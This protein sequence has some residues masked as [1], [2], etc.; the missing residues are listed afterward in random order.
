MFFEPPYQCLMQGLIIAQV[1][2]FLFCW[3]PLVFFMVHV[4]VWF[5]LDYILMSVIQVG[6]IFACF[7]FCVQ[8]TFVDSVAL[9]VDSD[10][11]ILVS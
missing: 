3:S 2:E 10:V 8:M 9:N 7:F 6:V 11:R 4:L 1:T 5:L